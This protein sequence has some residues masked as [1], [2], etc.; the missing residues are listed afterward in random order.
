MDPAPPQSELESPQKAVRGG[1]SVPNPATDF[2]PFFSS[3]LP[4][5]ELLQGWTKLCLRAGSGAPPFPMGYRSELGS[6]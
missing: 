5:P 2:S 3:L 1:P 6:C 4:H